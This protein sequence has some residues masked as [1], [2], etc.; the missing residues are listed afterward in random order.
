MWGGGQ[1]S[2]NTC[3]RVIMTNHLSKIKKEGRSEGT[4]G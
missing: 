4:G 3:K 2:E 1:G